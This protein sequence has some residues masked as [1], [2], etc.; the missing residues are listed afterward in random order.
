MNVA[1]DGTIGITG[2]VMDGMAMLG[3]YGFSN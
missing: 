2:T 1:L 3:N